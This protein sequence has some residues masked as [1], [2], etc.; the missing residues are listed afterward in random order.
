MKICTKNP[1]EYDKHYDAARY[2][3]RHVGRPTFLNPKKYYASTSAFTHTNF[4]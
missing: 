1:R 2:Y 3:D 4:E